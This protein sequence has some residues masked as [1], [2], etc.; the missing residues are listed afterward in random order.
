MHVQKGDRLPVSVSELH[1]P[2]ALVG[3]GD[4]VGEDPASGS[5][6]RLQGLVHAARRSRGQV[7]TVVR[8]KPK[9]CKQVRLGVP[10]QVQRDAMPGPGVKVGYQCRRPDA[11]TGRTAASPASP[12]NKGTVLH[13]EGRTASAALSPLH[14]DT[15]PVGDRV[16]AGAE[17]PAVQHGR[18]QLCLQLLNA[19]LDLGRLLHGGSHV[20]EGNAR[21]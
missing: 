8:T 2:V 7:G 1:D 16:A 9:P 20:R 18:A 4:V 13:A 17:Q 5:W 15:D 6:L 21:T 14:L 3:D 12:V 11:T 10:Q 19:R